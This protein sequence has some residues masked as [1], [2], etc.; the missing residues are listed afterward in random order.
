MVAHIKAQHQITAHHSIE[1]YSILAQ[2]NI[3]G[4]KIV[5]MSTA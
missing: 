1:F 3:I 4:I 2:L 5:Q